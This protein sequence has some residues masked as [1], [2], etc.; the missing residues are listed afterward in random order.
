MGTN[1]RSRKHTRPLDFPYSNR[2][3]CRNAIQPLRIPRASE[4]IHAPLV[5]INDNGGHEGCDDCSDIEAL[6]IAAS[7][8]SPTS[9][10]V[11]ALSGAFRCWTWIRPRKSTPFFDQDATRPSFSTEFLVRR[12]PDLSKA[13]NRTSCSFRSWSIG[14]TRCRET[15]SISDSAR[16][17][18]G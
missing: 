1:G 11:N 14:V 9:T 10:S 8:P 2:T 12:R 13:V 15:C 16:Y 4:C 17:S 6:A 18:S 3:F 7:R 5:G